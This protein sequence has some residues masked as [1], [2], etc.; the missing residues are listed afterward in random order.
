VV[1]PD[2]PGPTADQRLWEAGGGDV[3]QV[4]QLPEAVTSRPPSPSAGAS[5]PS[6]LPLSHPTSASMMPGTIDPSRWFYSLRWSHDRCLWVISGS[7]SGEKAAA[8]PALLPSGYLLA[9]L[10]L[11]LSPRRPWPVGWPVPG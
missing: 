7:R 3:H 1:H 10:A 5:Y 9:A 6:G 8:T 2:G 11:L 4:Y